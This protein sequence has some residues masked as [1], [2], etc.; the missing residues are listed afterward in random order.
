[1]KTINLITLSTVVVLLLGGC[2]VVTEPSPPQ[3]VSLPEKFTV[4]GDH[5]LNTSWWHRFEDQ[6]LD[7]LI[8]EALASNLSLQA[9]WERLEQS[10]AAAVKSG[11][12]LY[13]SV[14]LNAAA[15]SAKNRGDLST[16]TENFSTGLAASYEIDLWGRVRAN[17]DAGEYDYLASEQSL[18]TAAISLSAE[19]ASLWYKL[20]AQ[21]HQLK[22]LNNQIALN[23][24]NVLLTE[25]K[26]RS[27][28][29]KASDVLQQRQGLES[30]KGDLELVRNRIK[31]YEYQ[32]AL[33]L[34]K[35]AG[36][37]KAPD[38]APLPVID[39]LPQAGVPSE[40]LMQRP[41]VKAAFFALKASDRRLAAAVADR[42]PKLSITASA[43]SSAAK[44]SDLFNNWLLTL[45]GNLA[46]PLFDGGQR[47]AEAER[48]EALRNEKF[49]T[50]AET[51]LKA[52]KEVED[53]LSNVTHRQRYVE[54]LKRQ[55]ALSEASVSQI[56][57][58]Y[59]HGN[60]GFVNFLTARLS[61]EALQRSEITASQELID[62]TISLYRALSTGWE[63]TRKR[64]ITRN[65]HAKQ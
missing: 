28:Q 35:T 57:Q 21:S 31:L 22:L 10:R 7:L 32:M 25:R 24:K 61:H 52:L 47:R 11:A 19:V 16:H 1:M 55:V 30:V 18:R 38:V 15:S 26:F 63:P 23:E 65:D 17:A 2:G 51:L 34:G 44:S 45:A 50:Y 49:Y 37:Y 54:S 20:Q 53:A 4:S 62:D 59:L 41:D 33:L 39:T 29:A 5:A 48:N 13:P 56:R 58:Q 46:A 8:Q 42:Y 27:G 43:D 36:S 12:S 40:L 60:T 9:T 3:N 14:T 6:Q 64:P